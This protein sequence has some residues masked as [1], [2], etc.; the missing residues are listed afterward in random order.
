MIK[1]LL[2]KAYGLSLS[3]YNNPEN[4][5]PAIRG[6]IKALLIKLLLPDMQK[7]LY[8]LA[9]IYIECPDNCKFEMQ[10]CQC[11]VYA[12]AQE[13]KRCKRKK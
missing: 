1:E 4:I 12:A 13:G 10:C 9:V 5:I 8:N 7:V 11:S 3:L 6:N 2:E